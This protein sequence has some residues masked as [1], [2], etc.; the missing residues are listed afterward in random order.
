[1]TLAHPPAPDAPP[2]PDPA[3][4]P[5]SSKLRDAWRGWPGSALRLTLALLPLAWLTQK[6]GWADVA[7]RARDVGAANLALSF[8][9]LVASLA[10]ASARWRTMMRAYG[11]TATPPV[12]TLLRHNLVG[13]Y[14]NVL[15]SGVA[16]DAVRAHRLRK[17]MPDMASSLTVIFLERVAGLLGLCVV[18]AVAFVASDEM[19]DDVVARVLELGLLGALGF[20]TLMLATPWALAK[21]PALGGL[22]ARVPVFGTLALRV[23]PARSARGLAVSVAQSVVIQGLVVLS[24]ALLVR[25]LAP[26]VTLLVCA[27]VVPAVI[28][29]TYIPLTPGGLGQRELVFKYMF[30]LVGVAP[31][32]AVATSLLFFAMLMAL[33]G[34]GGLCL[35]AERALGLDPERRPD[36]TA[37]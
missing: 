30:G 3:P 27:R 35:V 5:R 34:L 8:A 4:A 11:A 9:T 22:I 15:P 19:H 23:P 26:G 12:L 1:M 29:T 24:V 18:A 31:D 33:A 10:L 2:M 17:A 32:A 13:Q 7:A 21:R 37:P 6:V 16:G 25:P 28:L 14:F 20:S 36:G